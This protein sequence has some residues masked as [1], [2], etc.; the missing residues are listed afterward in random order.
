MNEHNA[1]EMTF[2]IGYAKGK[3]DAVCEMLER[4]KAEKFHHKNKRNAG[5]LT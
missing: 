2:K 5:G 1:T 4:I 3:I